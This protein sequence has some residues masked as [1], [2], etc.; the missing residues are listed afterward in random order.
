MYTA[1][2]ADDEIMVRTALERMVD[3]EKEGF[4]LLGCYVNGKAALEACCQQPP[5]LVITDIK[6]PLCSG[7][8][9]ID[10]L[11]A[12][13]QQPLILVLSAFDDF[14]LVKDAF[15]KGAEDYLLKQDLGPEKLQEVLRSARAKLD[16]Q[17]RS[18]AAAS[19]S[20]A[21][22][23]NGLL[24]DVILHDAAP[25]VLPDLDKGYV[26]A[27]FFVDDLYREMARLGSDIQKTLIDPL[28]QLVNQVPLIRSCDAF[29]SFDASRHFLFYSLAPAKRSFQS[30]LSFLSLV[31]TAW[32]NYM[33]IPCTVGVSFVE[34][35]APEKRFFDA[36]SQAEVNT[37]LRYV[38]GP[39]GIYDFNAYSKFNP[40]SALTAGQ[41]QLPLIRAA[42]DADFV[43][44]HR[45]QQAVT[46]RL[47]EL[48][49]GKAQA[50]ALFYL[51]NVYYEIGFLD[52]QIAYKLGLDHQLYQRIHELQSQR[53]IV[54]YFMS[55]LRKIME[56]F[57]V[58]YTQ[59]TPDPLLKARRYIDSSYM[60][61]DLTLHEVAEQSGYNE[62]YFC[63]LFKRRFGSSYSDYL[64]QVRM[65]AAKELLATTDLRIYA[66]AEAV[67][68]KT[69]EHF[70]R[71][72][73]RECGESPG[74]YRQFHLKK[75]H[76]F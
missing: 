74:N 9:L 6:M 34:A 63:T 5:D 28:T 25:R 31:K 68:Y 11:H 72:F 26:L 24:K 66:I 36:L 33:N 42:I 7:L 75:D 62:K 57:E 73:K 53:E 1:I 51:F 20:T 18:S 17:G 76:D 46:S 67:G 2:V 70:M 64:T 61:P 38:L 71:L 58:N 10:G 39:G 45:E 44:A 54:I 47:M 3:W 56:Y 69:M 55:V 29:Y 52:V 50:Y 35:G 27:C 4:R 59:H 43:R 30:A 22:S 41:A 60:R 19:P 65:G 37:T 23:A 16:K 21:P 13:G 8:E 15:K 12:Q 49:L 14:Q 48:P 40:L 32:K